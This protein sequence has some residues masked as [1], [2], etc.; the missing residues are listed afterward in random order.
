[1][2]QKQEGQR[3][4]EQDWDRMRAR[5][6]SELTILDGRIRDAR[7]KNAETQKQYA[8]NMQSVLNRITA[9]I[10][11]LDGE[12][13]EASDAYQRKLKVYLEGAQAS[14]QRIL[15]SLKQLE[16]ERVEINAVQEMQRDIEHTQDEMQKL[17]ETIRVLDVRIEAAIAFA[18]KK[19]ELVLA[20]MVMNRVSIRL[21]DV[22]KSTGEIVDAFRLTYE[23]RDLRLLSLSERIRA[24]L[25]ISQAVSRLTRLDLP[26]F[27][28]NSESISRIDNIDLSSGQF[29]FAL[30]VTGQTLGMEPGWLGLRDTGGMIHDA[31]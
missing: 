9:R 2:A 23:G 16:Q 4:F 18:A 30:K 31:A 27:I 28:D 6:E 21:H 17:M 22:V 5:L 11:S 10:Q 7:E 29:I 15:M 24:G 8:E 20:P 25:E 3:R 19:A 1:M 12:L 26:V 13:T 14:R